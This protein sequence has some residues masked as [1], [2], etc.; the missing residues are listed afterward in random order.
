MRSNP[1]LYLGD[2]AASGAPRVRVNAR[3]IGG[4]SAFIVGFGDGEA[5]YTAQPVWIDFEM[6][7]ASHGPD[8][9]SL[10]T[11]LIA[12]TGDAT[13]QIRYICVAFTQTPDGSEGGSGGTPPPENEVDRPPRCIFRQS[14]FNNGTGGWTVSGAVQSGDGEILVP[15]GQTFSQSIALHPADDG[16]QTYTLTVR[17]ALWHYNTYVPDPANTDDVELAYDFPADSSFDTIA[18]KTYGDYADSDIVT[19]QTTFEIE[20]S[21]SGTFTLSPTLSSAPAGI[22]GVAIRDVC[23]SAGDEFDPDEEPPPPP[24]K[25]YPPNQPPTDGG[26]PF[27]EDCNAISEPSGNDI[28]PWIQWQWAKMSRFYNCELMILLNQMYKVMADGYR[29]FGWGTRWAQ[30]TVMRS[31][32]FLWSF[33]QWL[34]GHLSNIALGQT[35]TIVSTGETCGNVF[36]LIQTLIDGGF[37]YLN[38]IIAVLQQLMDYLLD[39]D[40]PFW[41]ILKDT[42]NQAF[43]LVRDVLEFFINLIN[44]IVSFIFSIAELIIALILMVVGQVLNLANFARDLIVSVISAWNNATPTPIPGMPDCSTYSHFW[45]K[46]VWVLDNTIYAKSAMFTVAGPMEIIQTIMIGMGSVSLMLWCIKTF[47]QTVADMGTAI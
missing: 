36:C 1:P 20:E 15:S 17:S 32:N 40:S 12:N 37:S 29:L 13:I 4:N 38:N 22:R 26:G 11:V 44:S 24:G 7:G 30:A 21:T 18:T 39:P 43:G 35:T 2:N 25:T 27:T 34:N 47:R 31:V 42:I 45:C 28:G 5:D 33:V 6:N 10:Y 19:H 41:A 8:A 3:T 9:G 23:I 14:S 16:P 46:G